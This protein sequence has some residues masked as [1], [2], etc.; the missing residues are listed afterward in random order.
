[1]V[2]RETIPRATV[3]VFTASGMALC[4]LYFQRTDMETGDQ[5]ALGRT[6]RLCSLVRWG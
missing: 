4:A 1:M 2:F 3:G 5:I 6:P